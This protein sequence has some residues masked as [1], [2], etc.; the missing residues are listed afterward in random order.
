M[1]LPAGPRISALQPPRPRVAR[2]CICT[3]WAWA[4]GTTRASDHAPAASPKK[5]HW[6]GENRYGGSPINRATPVH[7]PSES[8]FPSKKPSS[9][10]G[11]PMAMETIIWVWTFGNL[12]SEEAPLSD[13]Q[14]ALRIQ[15]LEGPLINNSGYT[16][17]QCCSAPSWDFRNGRKRCRPVCASDMLMAH[18]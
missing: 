2:G 13:Q 6:P 7:H 12:Q 10:W 9:Y 3:S 15:D 18:G 4:G 11:S 16:S 17:G 5:P 14:L 8:D 1:P